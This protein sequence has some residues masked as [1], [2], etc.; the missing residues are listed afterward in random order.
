MLFEY[1]LR[2]TGNHLKEVSKSKTL[3]DLGELDNLHIN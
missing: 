3:N 1:N 2:E